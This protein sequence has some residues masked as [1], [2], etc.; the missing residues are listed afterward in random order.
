MALVPSS[1]GGGIAIITTNSIVGFL[2]IVCVIL[3]VWARKLKGA[4]L[5]GSDYTCI[6]GLIFAFGLFASLIYDITQA[7][8]REMDSVSTQEM[9]TF[10][11]SVLAGLLLWTTSTTFIRISAILL[12]IRIF[13]LARFITL[14]WFVLALNLAY[15]IATYFAG[16]L[17]CQ[18]ITYTWDASRLGGHC[19]NW[20]TFYLWHGTQNLVLDLIVV[21]MP[22]PLLWRLQLPSYKKVTLTIIF[23][24]GLS[25]CA[26]T[27][28]RIIGTY[29]GR[30]SHITQDYISVSLLT[31]L[32][33]FLG[34]IS[35]SLPL[36][37]PVGQRIFALCG[38]ASV[39]N[40]ELDQ[41]PASFGDKQRARNV[42]SPY[43]LS[44][45]TPTTEHSEDV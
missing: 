8:G 15:A 27:L 12:F 30:I 16:F 36:A 38:R 42:A 13:P 20:R 22:M 40:S 32:E 4:R 17:M 5:D 45:S 34:I 39:L 9:V 37:R 31:M 28:G 29:Y 1:N 43:T 33:P 41:S 26:V 3:R 35:C 7:L 25:I 19:G 23:A 18:P 21:I 44:L 14:C 24:L 11:Q 2:A 10:Y 6:L